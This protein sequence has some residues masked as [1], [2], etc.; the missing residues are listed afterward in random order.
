MR[1]WGAEFHAPDH[2]IY[3]FSGGREFDSTDK[4][5]TGLYGVDVPPP[6]EFDELHYP[7]MDTSLQRSDADDLLYLDGEPAV[8]T[9]QAL[10]VESGQQLV[11]ENGYRILL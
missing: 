10:L 2:G 11:Q 8:N 1:A 5:L 9:Y 6:F 4:G 7:D 3:R